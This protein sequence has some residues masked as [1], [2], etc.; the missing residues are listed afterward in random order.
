MGDFPHFFGD[1]LLLSTRAKVILQDLME[2]SGEFLEMK[3]GN[4]SVIF[5]VLIDCKIE[6]VRKRNAQ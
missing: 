6:W 4:E 5:L 1:V 2:T 3:Y